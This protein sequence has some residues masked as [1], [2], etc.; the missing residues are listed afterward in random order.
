MLILNYQCTKIDRVDSLTTVIVDRQRNTLLSRM[1]NKFAYMSFVASFAASLALAAAMSL[2]F[3]TE[4]Q[5]S[6]TR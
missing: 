2:G 5:A 6:L 3:P 1:T 4:S